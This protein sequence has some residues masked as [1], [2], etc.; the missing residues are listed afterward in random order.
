MITPSVVDEAR[1]N[2]SC[3]ANILEGDRYDSH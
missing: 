2:F 1:D 3:A